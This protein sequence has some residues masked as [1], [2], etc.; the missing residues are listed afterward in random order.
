M[1]NYQQL[2]NIHHHI[3]L[4]LEVGHS[5]GYVVILILGISDR[6]LG[7][8][9]RSTVSFYWA[10]GVF[11]AAVQASEQVGRVVGQYQA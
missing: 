9:R 4:V 10:Q 1:T 11:P 7:Q 8:S 5:Y 2:Q 6:R 3:H